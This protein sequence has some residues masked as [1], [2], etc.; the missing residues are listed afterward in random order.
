M[1]EVWCASSKHSSQSVSKANGPSFVILKCISLFHLGCLGRALL[2][3]SEC[4]EQN[5]IAICKAKG[6]A[7][8]TKTW[9]GSWDKCR[10]LRERHSV[11]LQ[12]K[13]ERSGSDEDL[14]KS[15]DGMAHT[16]HER[17]TSEVLRKSFESSLLP[18]D[19]WDFTGRDCAAWI[20][21]A[22]FPISSFAVLCWGLRV[23]FHRNGSWTGLR[24]CVL[25]KF[26]EWNILLKKHN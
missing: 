7:G 3:C 25:T 19:S 21:T 4:R 5:I 26:L 10:V 14:E 8:M 12:E 23:V 1:E 13:L 15:R 24:L 18:A 22:R 20:W 2:Q 17:D 9:A 11:W 6:G 16:H